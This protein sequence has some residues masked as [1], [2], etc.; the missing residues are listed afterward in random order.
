MGWLLGMVERARARFNG[1][2]P[3]ILSQE[4]NGK[5]V[6]FCGK[7]VT[8]VDGM[9][10]LVPSSLTTCKNILVTKLLENSI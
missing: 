9:M 4:G 1:F 7:M 8:I 5:V 6:N 10:Y 3:S 2:G